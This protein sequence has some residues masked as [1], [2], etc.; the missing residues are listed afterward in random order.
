MVKNKAM[1]ATSEVSK[2]YR[3]IDLRILPFLLVCYFIS[4]L[5]RV[6]IGF[7]KLHMQSDLGLSDAAYGLG[8][9]IFFIGYAIFE[10]PSNLLLTKIGARKTLS[11]VMLL[12]GITSSCMFL[13]NNEI[14]FYILRFFLGVFEAGFA[15][16]M[17]YYL[18]LWY[19]RDRLARVMAITMLAGPI[20]SII[21]A[22]LS[23]WIMTEFAGIGGLKGWQWMF[24][25]EGFPAVILGILALKLLVDAPSQAKW[26]SDD[27]KKIH[28]KLVISS[29]N[30]HSSF[31]A[32]LKDPRIYLMAFGY[33]CLICGIYSMSFWLPSLIRDSGVNDLMS[34]GFL[35]AIP[36]IA[37]IIFMQIFGRT[38]DIY[39]ERRW[40]TSIPAFIAAISLAISTVFTDN[41]LISLIFLSLGTAFIWSAYTVFWAIPAQYLQG[42][43]A[44][45]GIAVINTIGLLG[46]FVSP[47]LIG[48]LKSYT[49]SSSAGV[50]AMALIVGFGSILL[51]ANKPRTK[52]SLT[53]SPLIK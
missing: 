24:L 22:P 47:T 46:G 17:I 18:T 11:R 42:T 51:A 1:G 35:S 15:P 53:N 14:N 43:A 38:S 30:A 27:E 29:D 19:G 10:T 23:T 21:G 25:I 48:L 31:R 41:L 45:G 36:Y 52:V 26:L 12:W 37:A 33:F 6:N 4:Y 49:G 13:V 7:A 3:K 20:G 44:A 40:H 9:G 50:L 32:A 28:A 8:A 39:N 2:I 16:G 5:D 34:I